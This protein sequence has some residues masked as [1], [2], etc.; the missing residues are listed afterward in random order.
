MISEIDHILGFFAALTVVTSESLSR[1]RLMLSFRVTLSYFSVSVEHFW[2]SIDLKAVKL[3]SDNNESVFDFVL[4][5]GRLCND[6]LDVS[7]DS[8]GMCVNSGDGILSIAISVLISG[9]NSLWTHFFT[10]FL[11]LVTSSTSMSTS[12]TSDIPDVSETGLL[13]SSDR[14]FWLEILSSFD[15]SLSGKKSKLKIE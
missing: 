10:G 1:L 13:S 3:S 12:E 5:W 6:T 4:S 11:R 14:E 7:S 15:E 8:L 2:F 9:E